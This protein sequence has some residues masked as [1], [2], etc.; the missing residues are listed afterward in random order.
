M[1]KLMLLI[2][3]TAC[4]DKPQKLITYYGAD[5]C[6]ACQE[7]KPQAE[8]IAKAN[9][10]E[11]KEVNTDNYSNNKVEGKAIYF[12]PQVSIET[13]DGLYYYGPSDTNKLVELIHHYISGD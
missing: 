6:P 12:I 8:V 10:F 11:F 9:R 2:L 7:F 4:A 3:L 5:W 1:N 13:E